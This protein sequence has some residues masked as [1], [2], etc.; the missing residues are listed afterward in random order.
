M[1]IY[2]YFSTAINGALAK[3]NWGI[4][5]ANFI[6]S[7]DSFCF[8]FNG[9]AFV[10]IHGYIE[11]NYVANNVILGLPRPNKNLSFNVIWGG[12]GNKEFYL[13]NEGLLYYPENLGAGSWM[14]F[15]LFYP[16]A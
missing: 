8:V 13:N 6:L 3:S 12:I 15:E 1:S 2:L 11:H 4:G 7:A 16:V 9:I 14:S 10:K 5:T